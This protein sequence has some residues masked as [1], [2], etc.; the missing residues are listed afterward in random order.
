MCN[1]ELINLLVKFKVDCNLKNKFGETALSI[2]SA[3]LSD[4][5]FDLFSF[6]VDL[7]CNPNL[8]D[9]VLGLSCIH[10]LSYLGKSKFLLKLVEHKADFNLKN[11]HNVSPIN[12][13]QNNH[14][15]LIKELFK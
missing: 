2:T 11:I 9:N 8:N 5:S 14:P 12:I 4:N 1:L 10:F 15:H 3:S 13:L 7:G 6:F